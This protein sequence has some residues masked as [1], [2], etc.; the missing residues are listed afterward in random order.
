M[1]KM[2]LKWNLKVQILILAILGSTG[3]L[4]SNYIYLNDIET[5]ENINSTNTAVFTVSNEHDAFFA[6]SE[7]GNRNQRYMKIWFSPAIDNE[8]YGCAFLSLLGDNDHEEVVG[9]AIG[10]I[11]S[12]G[13]CFDAND[14]P[15]PSFV[16]Y[17]PS[18][19]LIASYNSFWQ[20]ILSECASVLEVREWYRTHNMGGWWGYQIQW[21]DKNGDAVIVSPTPFQTIAFTK[22]T[23]DYLISTN[24]NPVNHSQGWYPCKR[25]ELVANRLDEIINEREIY[26]RDISSIL[27]AVSV[28]EKGDYIGTVY[29][30]I[31]ELKTQTI[32]LHIQRD[33]DNE[34]T[35]DL[36]EELQKGLHSYSFPILANTTT[37]NR[38]WILLFTIIFIICMMGMG[39][40]IDFIN[41]RMFSENQTK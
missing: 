14:I 8:T 31:F 28:P 27:N 3:I 18:F 26:R 30:N 21:A 12:E 6:N 1:R 11:N 35:L 33:F 37:S 32:Y 34:I 36:N 39:F 9:N 23:S 16:R 4:I 19:G 5:D 40:F 38:Y 13:L 41:K 25:Y 7:D 24:F 10:G 29:S 17:S 22:K 15:P 2:N 20:M